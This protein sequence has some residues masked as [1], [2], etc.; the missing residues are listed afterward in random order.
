[1][2]FGEMDMLMNEFV[3]TYRD[4]DDM[5]KTISDKRIPKEFPPILKTSMRAFEIREKVTASMGFSFVCNSWVLPL[6][7]WI[8]GRKCLEVMA[9]SGALSCALRRSSIDIIAT[10]NYSWDRWFDDTRNLWTDVVQKDCIHSI[11]EY[12]KDVDIIIMSWP[13]MDDNAYKCLLKMREVN[14][15]CVMVYIGEGQGGCTANADFFDNISI[16]GDDALFNIAS[17]Q[18]ISWQGIHDELYLIK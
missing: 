11:E 3:S 9:G 15:D 2:H 14:K 6:A 12:G 10:D 4:V 16:V 18:Y 5:L 13:Y 8:G 17:Q 1:M 7:H